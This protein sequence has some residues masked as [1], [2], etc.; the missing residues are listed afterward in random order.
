MSDATPLWVQCNHAGD[1]SVSFEVLSRDH[2][3]R[4]LAIGGICDDFG[5]IAILIRAGIPNSAAAAAVSEAQRAGVAR[6]AG[7]VTASNGTLPE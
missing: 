6:V 1:G 7:T 5:A 2:A 4:P 3:G